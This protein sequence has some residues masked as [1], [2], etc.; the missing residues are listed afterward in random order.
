MAYDQREQWL[1]LRLSVP[2]WRV[3]ILSPCRDAVKAGDH[4][5][6]K[7]KVPTQAADLQIVMMVVVLM[8]VLMSAPEPCTGDRSQPSG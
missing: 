5:H 7:G 1:N 6:G 3:S 4:A 8:V 2:Q